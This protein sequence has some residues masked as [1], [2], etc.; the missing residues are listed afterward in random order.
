MR[1]SKDKR[2]QAAIVGVLFLL[3]ISIVTGGGLGSLGVHETQNARRRLSSLAAYVAAE[4]GV[5]D[6]AYRL[7]NGLTVDNTETLTV[8]GRTVTTTVDAIGN[9]K[10]ILGDASVL[11]A[12][13]RIQANLTEAT[14][15]SAFTYGVQVGYVGLE[16]ENNTTV[17]GSV[18][19]NGSISGGSNAVITGDAWVAGGTAATAD[20]SQETQTADMSVRDASATR[21]AAQSFVPS[22]TANVSTVN[23]YMRKVGNPSNATIRIVSDNGGVP[24]T[25]DSLGSGTLN[26]GNVTA[27]Y[28]WVSVAVNSSALA[29]GATYWIVIDNSSNSGSN[30]YVLG[31]ASDT[32]YANGTFLYSSSWTSGSWTAPTPG[33]RDAAFRIYMGVSNTAL[34][35][36]EVHGHAHAHTISNSAVSGDA[37]YQTI[38]GSSVGGLSHPG[39]TDPPA[40]TLP[41]SEAELDQFKAWG[42]A[43]G[44]CA[45]PDCD[46][47]GNYLLNNAAGAMGPIRVAG[48]LTV[49]NNATL[50]IGGTIHIEGDLLF[51]NNCT[52]QMSSAYG[53]S[54]GIIIVDGTATIRNNCDLAG[55]GTPGSY[56]MIISTSNNL[57]DP[58][59]IDVNNN[60]TGAIFYAA[61][62]SLKLENNTEVKE[63]VGQKIEME[64]NATLIYETGLANVNFSAGPTGGYTIDRWIEA[65]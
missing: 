20:Q 44:V 36:M 13:R 43:G 23:L 22:I 18:Y 35:G 57:S 9:T 65:E 51:D 28:G 26:A 15:G 27:N 3:A 54:S 62:G 64:N 46:V 45:P 63:A 11:N 24:H 58:P 41:I 6:V 30:Y 59:A 16:M 38:S 7:M 4:S 52:V 34:T 60:A 12:N 39:S 10:E 37:Y 32:A 5:E 47:S 31:G 21:D 25:S 2:G 33:S 1:L 14:V 49:D 61:N 29:S 42:D 8:N 19:A 50:T 17:E 56:L 53:A 48:D 40:Q 55:S